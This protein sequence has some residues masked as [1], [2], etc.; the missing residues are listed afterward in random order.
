MMSVR[1]PRGVRTAVAGSTA[2]VAVAALGAVAL[3]GD[4]WAQ[5]WTGAEQ[6]AVAAGTRTVAV[7]PAEQV[8]V[9]PEPVALPDG[10]DVGDS[11]FAAAPVPTHDDL[12]AVVLSGAEGSDDAA[13]RS[14]ALDGS[15]P[16]GLGQSR[17][18]GV[19]VLRATPVTGRAF[20]LAGT[21]TSVTTQG[22]LRGL[23]AGECAAPSTSQWLV[24]GRTT[25]GATTTLRVQ[26]PTERPATV[27][28]DAFGPSGK[29]ALGGGGTFTVAAHAQVTTR[30]EAVAP[31]QERLVVH[32]ASTG[33]RV[34]AD[35]Q[36]QGIEGL[37]PAGVDLVTAG[38]SP[39]TALAV[40]AVV[41][42]GEAVDD[43]H[44]PRLRLLAPGE[45]DGAARIRVYGPSGEVTLRGADAVDLRAG[46]VTDVPLGG[47]PAGSYTVVVDAD[48][49]VVGGGRFDR[50]GAQPEDSVVSG[51]PY[52]VAWSRAQGVPAVAASAAEAPL[53]QLALT[54]GARAGLVLTGVPADRGPDVDPQ[55]V[56]RVRVVTYDAEGAELAARDVEVPAG[57]SVALAAASL[58]PGKAPAAVRVD[59]AQEP[60]DAGVGVT[61]SAVL[62]A[63][64]GTG[65]RRTLV[66]ALAP[67]GAV[68]AAG[69]VEVRSVDAG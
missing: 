14:T 27:T 68:T 65:T 48:V 37:V 69:D 36:T 23:A 40:G 2:V 16:G 26:N 53:G 56:A 32:V 51:T 25:V 9:C 13:P 57:T 5:G 19:R 39:R 41:S 28:L 33:A 8:R 7:A 24:G 67:T 34:T 38:A 3:L 42:H 43:P 66:S 49:P 61:W 12:G 15:E 30:L 22:D 35:L 52:D 59:R 47:L 55:G 18:D 11:A 63:D 21:L 4:Q 17:A 44:A 64:D 29:V 45:D 58:S 1:L 10:A 20:R 54:S 6:R 60:G 62:V 50:P 46:V 31:E